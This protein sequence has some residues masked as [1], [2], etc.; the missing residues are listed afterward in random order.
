MYK[1]LIVDDEYYIRQRLKTCIDWEA[2]GFCIVAEAQSADEAFSI[3]KHGGISLAVIDISM[4]QKDGLTLIQELREKQIPIK[5]IILSGYGTF[6]YAQKAIQYNVMQYLL[7]PIDEDDLISS[8]KQIKKDL[9][10]EQAINLIHQTKRHADYLLSTIRKENYF[11]KIFI[12]HLLLTNDIQ[13]L[14]QQMARH[15]LITGTFCRIL[16]FDFSSCYLQSLSLEDLQMFRHAAN[17]I[18]CEIAP[19]DLKIINASDIYG[20]GVLICEISGQNDSLLFPYMEQAAEKIKEFMQLDICFGCSPVF[21]LT[22]KTLN[23]EYQ[24]ALSSYVMCNLRGALHAVYSA[25]ADNYPDSFR[26]RQEL[27]KIDACFSSGRE[28]ELSIAIDNFFLLLEHQ[29]YNFFFLEQKLSRLIM[30]CC[31][32]AIQSTAINP[33]SD[34][35]SYMMGFKEILFAGYDLSYIKEKISQLLLSMLATQSMVTPGS[36]KELLVE[37]AV[38]FIDAHYSRCDMSLTLLSQ[39]LLISPS[40]LCSIFKKIKG[41]S[42][43]QYINQTRLKKARELLTDTGLTLTEIAERVGY[44]DLF[45]FSKVFKRHFGVSPSAY[46]A[47]PS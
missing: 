44:N 13:P 6:A 2:E 22:L 14:E 41:I 38:K 15:G 29:N 11:K 33:L 28:K 19:P 10:S 24:H 3:L 17:N 9:D 47:P 27:E 46:K 18:L 42:V 43:N 39:N 40:Y 8:L 37:E 35:L 7:K 1:V 12:N 36:T 45:Y 5:I 4:P 32:K 20:H 30:S 26:I 34:D 31:T 23:L 21:S 16:V 25:A